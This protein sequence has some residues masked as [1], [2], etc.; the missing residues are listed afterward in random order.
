M[1]TY[2][3]TSTRIVRFVHVNVVSLRVAYLARLCAESTTLGYARLC[4]TLEWRVYD[5][6]RASAVLYMIMLGATKLK[7]VVVRFG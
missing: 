4:Y 5:G 7:G 6:R 1:L 3:V 2:I